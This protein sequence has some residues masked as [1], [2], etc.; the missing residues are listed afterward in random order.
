M[1][2][3]LSIIFL[4]VNVVCAFAAGQIMD[5]KGRSMIAGTALGFFPSVVG[6]LIA[7]LLPPASSK[8]SAYSRSKTLS[9]AL[10]AI[11]GHAGVLLERLMRLVDRCLERPR[12]RA[13]ADSAVRFPKCSSENADKCARTFN[14]LVTI[15]SQSWKIQGNWSN[16]AA[17]S[18]SGY[19]NVGCIQTS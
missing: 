4:V 6:L 18:R 17:N 7:V 5:G 13:A 9:A 1:S 2:T 11:P 16:A 15:G 3:E 8:N 12:A 19:A 10:A 14:G